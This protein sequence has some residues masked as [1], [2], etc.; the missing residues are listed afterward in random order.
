[1]ADPGLDRD[2][3]PGPQHHCPAHL[4]VQVPDTAPGGRLDPEA[5]EPEVA[6]GAATAVELEQRRGR[7][8]VLGARERPAVDV[9]LP[10]ALAGGR[11]L[12][13]LVEALP[14]LSPAFRQA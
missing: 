1:P 5:T 9:G 8:A 7:A 13:Y 4:L 2:P 3:L 12:I 11:H 14:A 6:H 10:P